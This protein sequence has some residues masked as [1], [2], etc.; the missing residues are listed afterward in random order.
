MSL[1]TSVTCFSSRRWNVVVLHGGDSAEREISLQSGA[2]VAAALK[3]AGHAV[4]LLD[5]A[6]QS[7]TE[8]SWTNVD[9]AMIVLHGTHGEDGQI[10]RELDALGVCYTGSNAAASFLAFHKLL[11]K[12][13]FEQYGLLTPEYRVIEPQT[14]PAMAAAL[15]EDLGYPLVV[16]PEAQGSS[17]GVSIL[18]DSEYFSSAI[19]LA[20]GLSDI[21]LIER[22]IAGQEWT[23]P[24]LDETALFPIRIGTSHQFFD[25]EAKYLD[26]RTQYEVMTDESDSIAREIQLLSL[27]AC[28]SLGCQ[29]VSR[30]DLRV[31]AAGTAWLLEV[32][33][34]PGMT[35]HSLVPKSAHAH[36]W[37][38]SRLCEEMI[39]SALQ[40]RKY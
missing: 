37:P 28:R 32:N 18:A 2:A 7:V 13:R 31:D 23:V 1:P 29:G 5:P 6:E 34:V 35:N 26:E 27:Q 25:F 33:T 20:Q 30:V 9:V 24:V 19:T 3:S 12:R 22:A 39:L 14:T 16:K 11:A 4:T 21:V 8:F 17:L 10:Q 38:M 15:A 36:G 40:L